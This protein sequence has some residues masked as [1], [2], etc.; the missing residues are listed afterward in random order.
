MKDIIEWLNNRNIQINNKDLIHQAFMHSSYANEHRRNHDNERLEFMGDAV[1]ELWTSDK[2]YKH[3]PVLKEGEMTTLRAQ[4]VC[5]KALSMYAKT[6]KLNDFLL[7][8]IGEEKSGGRQRDS[9]IA[10]MFEAFLGA[11]YLD[12]GM[13]PIDN[14]LSEVL[15]PCLNNPAQANL[16]IDYKTKLQ[17]YVQGDVRKTVSYELVSTH[18]PANN[19]VFEMRV[20]LDGIVLGSGKGNSKKK[21]EQEAAR[22]AFEKMVK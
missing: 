6:L 2:L 9:I 19:P 13:E 15:L 18:G 8:G 10:D 4:L 16:Q 17:E 14:I 5:E 3:K 21:A 12:Q 11:L 7:L 20:V 1:L 22:N